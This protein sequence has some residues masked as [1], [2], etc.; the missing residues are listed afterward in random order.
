[1]IA[2]KKSTYVLGRSYGALSNFTE[3]LAQLIIYRKPPNDV[4]VQNG[5]KYGNG[6]SEKLNLIYKKS[7]RKQPLLIYIHGGGFISGLVN[8]RNTYCSEFAKEG[9]FAVNI[10]YEDAPK[11]IFPFQI[12]QCL[13]AIDWVFDHA[14]EYNIDT[15]KILLAGESAGSY[16]TYY[17]SG[18]VNNPSLLKKLNLDFK[19]LN[20]FKRSA[21]IS[22]CG[23]IDLV[24]LSKS[25]FPGLKIMIESF[26]DKTI[27]EIKANAS[28][29]EI[30]IMS[31]EITKATPPSM[32]I[33]AKNDIIKSESLDFIKQ[34]ISLG[35]PNKSFEGTGLIS[36]HGFPI[37]TITKKGK[38]CLKSTLDF[39]IPYIKE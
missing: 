2:V 26:T 13:K 37:A 34:L 30:R 35:V 29:E 6:P 32:I 5:I 14:D 31:P 39:V 24:R 11:Q 16:F 21:I 27:K 12:N 23:A 36:F 22:N 20:K 9:L 3:L 33:Y 38:E 15:S 25:K 19:H 10:D 28:R 7:E 1:M 4:I 17:I 18:I 8:M